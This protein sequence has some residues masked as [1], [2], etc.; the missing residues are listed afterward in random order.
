VCAQVTALHLLIGTLEQCKRLSAENREALVH[1]CA[2]YSSRLL[3]KPEQ[4]RAAY[5]CSHLFWSQGADGD[6]VLLCL[7]RAL[8]IANKAQEVCV[9]VRSVCVCVRSV[10]VC[11]CDVCVCV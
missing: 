10:C 8:K 7:K 3:L 11:V 4:C 9:C 5:A 1:K 2:G 6:N